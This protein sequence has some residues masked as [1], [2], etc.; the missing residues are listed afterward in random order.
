MVASDDVGFVAPRTLGEAAFSLLHDAIL[1]GHLQPGERLVIERLART[2][3]MSPVP[4]REAIL[5]LDALG[6]VT[7]VP[8][9]GASVAK[10]SFDDFRDVSELRSSLESL[11]IAR[12]A[13]RFS[14]EDQARARSLLEVM[15]SEPAGSMGRCRAHGELH[16][17]LYRASRSAWLMRLIQPLWESSERYRL[18]LGMT[19]N[20]VWTLDVHERLVRACERHEPELAANELSDHFASTANSFAARLV[21]VRQRREERTAWS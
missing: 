18:M 8:H 13:Q 9:K 20:T 5:H 7:H 14:V 16:M 2:L 15:R 6:L 17:F 1:K 10:L 19:L 21:A 11:A 4:V 12:A 3:K